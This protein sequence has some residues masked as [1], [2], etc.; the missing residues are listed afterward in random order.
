MT[1]FD[2]FVGDLVA[3]PEPLE[4]KRGS[5]MPTKTYPCQACGGTGIWRQRRRNRHGDDHCFACKGT[6]VFKT[7]PEAR[8]KAKAQRRQR[9]LDKAAAAREINCSH[10]GLLEWLAANTGWNDFARSLVE[11]D[12]AGRQWSDAQV[13]AAQSMR[14]KTEAK[15][16]AKEAERNAQRVEVDLAPIAAMFATAAQSGYKRP[17][18]RAEGVRLKPGKGGALYVLDD[19]RTELGHYGEQPMYLGKIEDGS[20]RPGRNATEATAP[21]LLAIATDPRGSAIKYGQRTGRC[22][23]C[24]RELTRHSSIEAGIGPICADKWGL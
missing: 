6:G 8:A 17:L 14:A 22:S 19:E 16:A 13:R 12:M 23:C 3:N 10:D 20:F 15:R 18:Y 21:A 24:G 5:T 7:S 2:D 1:S 4:T 11:Q 9:K